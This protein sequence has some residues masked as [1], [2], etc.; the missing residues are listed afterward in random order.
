MTTEFFGHPLVLAT[1]ISFKLV[2]ASILQNTTRGKLPFIKVYLKI[3]DNIILRIFIY[4]YFRNFNFLWI[5]KFTN[6]NV[7]KKPVF[8]NVKGTRNK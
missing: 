3:Y 2:C 7:Y 8:A 1:I 5:L 4:I 6:S